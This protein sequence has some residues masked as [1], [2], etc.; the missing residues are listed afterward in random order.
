MDSAAN[1]QRRSEKKYIN[2]C[3]VGGDEILNQLKLEIAAQMKTDENSITVYQE[4]WGWAMEFSNEGVN[5]LLAVNNSSETESDETHFSA[6]TQATRR[7]KGLFIDKW[8]DAEDELANFSQI[9]SKL[10][11]NNGFRQ[12]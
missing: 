8:I 11:E 12:K 10:A 7:E 2:P 6:Y 4:D 9:V 5:Y 3:C 1:V